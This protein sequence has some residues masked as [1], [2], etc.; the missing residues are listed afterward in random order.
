MAT[1]LLKKY[2]AGGN[3]LALA[4]SP[5]SPAIPVRSTSTL[6][7]EYSLDG[8]PNA[9]TVKPKNGSLPDPTKLANLDPTTYKDNSPEGASF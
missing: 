2:E 1:S 5:A 8:I 7:D 6:H 4:G 3:P 9:A